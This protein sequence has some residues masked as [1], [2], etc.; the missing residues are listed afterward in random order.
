LQKFLCQC[1]LIKSPAKYLSVQNKPCKNVEL[2][3]AHRNVLSVR[4]PYFA[5]S[6]ELAGATLKDANQNLVSMAVSK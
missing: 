4:A 3:E 2:T 6:I 1:K 5:C